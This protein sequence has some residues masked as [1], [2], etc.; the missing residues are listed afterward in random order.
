MHFLNQL[1]SVKIHI[2]KKSKIKAK[3]R[4]RNKKWDDT[5]YNTYE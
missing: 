1:A 4:L 3:Q 2:H 5:I